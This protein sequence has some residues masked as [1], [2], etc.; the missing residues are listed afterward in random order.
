MEIWAFLVIIAVAQHHELLL[1]TQGLHSKGVLIGH[2]PQH[3][4]AAD[5]TKGNRST[6]SKD[7]QVKSASVTEF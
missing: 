5:I 7:L 6:R 4:F 2:K 3:I 1:A